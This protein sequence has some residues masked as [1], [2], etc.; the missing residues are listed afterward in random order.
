MGPRGLLPKSGLPVPQCLIETW[1]QS[2]EE[3]EKSSF[4][5]FCQAKGMHS[6]LEPEELCPLL[7][8]LYTLEGLAF[9]F[10]F[11]LAKFQSDYSWHQATQ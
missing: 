7:L 6:R 2:L 10:F 1:R 3:I 4:I 8:D 5:I 11:P 9:F